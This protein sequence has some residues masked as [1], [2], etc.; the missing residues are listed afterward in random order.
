MRGKGE[1]FYKGAVPGV[2]QGDRMLYMVLG[3]RKNDSLDLS[4]CT[5]PCTTKYEHMC[6]WKKKS[7][8]MS[9]RSLL[10]EGTQK[11]TIGWVATIKVCWRT[12]KTK[13]SKYSVMTSEPLVHNLSTSAHCERWVN[14]GLMEA[15]RSKACVCLPL[16]AGGLQYSVPPTSHL[17]SLLV[18][19]CVVN[20]QCWCLLSSCF[21]N[22]YEHTNIPISAYNSYTVWTN[23]IINQIQRKL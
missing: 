16:E 2:S 15:P 5:G 4:N 14:A 23:K 1:A 9:R 22:L 6:V 21:K 20:S 18:N 19:L 3:W 10:G 13:S 8:R 12:E 11:N 7:T 17:H